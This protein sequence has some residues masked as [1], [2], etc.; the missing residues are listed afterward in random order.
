MAYVGYLDLGTVPLIDNYLTYQLAAEA[1]LA[2]VLLCEPCDVPP[3]AWRNRDVRVAPWWDDA[4]PASREF[5]GLT[6]LEFTGLSFPTRSREVTSLAHAGGTLGRLTAGHREIGVRASALAL[7]DA[8]MSYGMA[9]LAWALRH[10]DQTSDGTSCGTCAGSTA[11]ILAYCPQDPS[12]ESA[13]RT[14]Y[15]VGLLEWPADPKLGRGA[16]SCAG[17]RVVTGELNFTLAAGRPWLHGPLVPLAT[18]LGFFTPTRW[19]CQGWVAHKPGTKGNP[20]DCEVSVLDECIQWMPAEEGY[21][22]TDSCTHIRANVLDPVQTTGT[23]T[24]TLGYKLASAGGNPGKL[25]VVEG[26]VGI[27]NAADVNVRVLYQHPTLAGWPVRPGHTVTFTAA[28]AA[29]ARIAA[30]LVWLNGDGTEIGR[31]QEADPG[32]GIA[33]GPA[34]ELARY[35]RPEIMFMDRLGAWQ[36]IGA[37]EMLALPP[38]TRPGGV[39]DPNPYTGAPKPPPTLPV[40]GDPASCIATLTPAYASTHVDAGRAPTHADMVPSIVVHAGAKPLK[41]FSIKIYRS[42]PGGT[43]EPENLDECDLVAQF[44]VPYL[45]AGTVLSMD[46]RAG[47][48]TKI[49]PDGSTEENVT[50]FNGTGRPIRELPTFSAAESWCVVA[51]ADRG[52]IVDPESVTAT[53]SIMA[54]PRWEAA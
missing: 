37:A 17:G 2:G 7:S 19:P 9:W 32:S 27:Q 51:I 25:A 3:P 42:T 40:A 5:L 38:G 31:T 28:I 13:W 1:G 53:M 39:C 12:D 22:Y 33:E 49:C 20:L 26:R 29:S 48:I 46:G 45:G 6:G 34:P 52:E 4:V 11:R 15:E 47:C 36:A 54:S 14:M 30:S 41:K 10:A 43:C 24:T 35:V 18:N 23:G 21:C 8:G 50:L 44:G 16:A